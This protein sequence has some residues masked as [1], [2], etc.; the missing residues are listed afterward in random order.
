M[1]DLPEPLTPEDCD[2]RNIPMPVELL[3]ALAAD[4]GIDP[5]W[6]IQFA[7][8]NGMAIGGLN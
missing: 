4:A 3:R 7:I 8:E 6:A 5:D 1:T 2:T